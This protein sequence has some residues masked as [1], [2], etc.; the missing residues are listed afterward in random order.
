MNEPRPLAPA[1]TI[2]LVR[3]A[4]ALEVLM[5]ER[6]H[7]IDFAS[8]ALVFPGG[9]T[10]A[11][12]SDARWDGLCDGDIELEE[13][14]Y[15]I[16]AVREAFEESGMLLARAAAQRGAGAPLIG[17]EAFQSLLS[18]R[19]AIAAGKASFVEGIAEAQLVLA[20]DALTPFA[21]WRTP[22]H[23]PKRFDT[24]FYIAHTPPEQ[25]ALC[26][27]WEAVD[28]CWIEPNEALAAGREGRRTVIFPTRLN[29]EMLAQ[30]PTAEAAIKAAQARKIVIVE[31]QVTKTEN[32]FVLNIPAEAGYSVTSEFMDDVMPKPA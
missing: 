21:H 3:D 19:D 22:K 2:M 13:R 8:G 31:P 24:R 20:L 11:E 9:K 30:S 5:V 16:S 23:M 15:R 17:P 28:A 25:E 29:I 7:Q 4:P 26:D 27:G 14:A 6:H 1:S 10:A 12:D 18:R 32:G